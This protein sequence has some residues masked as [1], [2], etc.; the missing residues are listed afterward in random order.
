MNLRYVPYPLLLLIV[1]A[2]YFVAAEIGL[3]QASLH[4]NV[5]PVWPPT[6]FAIAAVWLLGY[7]I[8]PGILLGAFLANLLTGVPIATAGGISV[9]NTLE[10]IT[11]VFLLRHFVGLRNP[12]YRAQDVLRFVLIAGA[13]SPAVSATIGNV[14]LCLGGA[15]A[16]ASFG[17]LWITWWLGDAVGALVIAPLLLTWV[18]ESARRWA[19]RRLAEA[20]L[21]LVSLSVVAYSISGA[22]PASRVVNYSLWRL[23]YA[24]LLWAAFRFG[25]SGVATTIAL[26]LGIAVWATRQGFGPIVGNTPNESLLLLQIFVAAAATTFL[27]LAAIVNERKRAEE[28]AREK[29]SELEEI[30]NHTP[31]MLTRCSCDLRYLFVSRAYAEMIGRTPEELAGKPIAEIMGEEGLKTISPHIEQVLLGKRVEYETE[32]SFRGVGAPCLH[33]V[34]TPDR[35]TQGNVTGWFAS[36]I[37]ITDRK[38]AEEERERLLS[39]E[40]SMRSEAERVSRLKDEFLATISHE[41]RT[42]LNAILGWSHVLRGGRIDEA[43]SSRVLETIERNAKAQ[44]QLIEDLLDVSRIIS[45]KLRLDVK[46]VDLTSVIKAAIDSFQHAADAKGIQLQMVLDPA[47]GRI[48]GDGARLQQVVW[49]LLSNAVKFSTKGGLVQVRLERADSSA[50]I[51]VSDTGEGIAPEFLPYVFDRFQQADGTTT[52]RYGGLGLGLAIAR[53]IVEIHG[54][55]IEAHSAGLRQG[56]S[57]TVRLP[58]VAV[59]ASG[60][61]PTLDRGSAIQEQAATADASIL[62]GLRVLAVDDEP[63]TR[64]MLKAVLE[65][66]G[67]DVA[68]AASAREAFETLPGFGPDVLVCD[69]GMPEEDG[70]TL[71]RKVRALKPEHGGKTRAIALTGYVR[72]EERMRA[73]E[74]GYQMFVPK[75][76]EPDELVSIIASLVGRIEKGKGS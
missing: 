13:L 58:L 28:V 61:L 9:G 74:S 68:T 42:P 37:D 59:R 38:L 44:A 6:G 69:I 20:A 7:R 64:D 60:H 3:S 12:F 63:D 25:P 33:V 10:A 21:L 55:T 39:R 40:R 51:T 36:I 66:Y 57:F 32:V 24:F 41:L 71:I 1:A 14:S 22:V 27:L 53:H 48:Q 62:Y 70:Y 34:Y 16:W 4:T 75:P 52:R 67:A 73:L 26:F 76:V 5:S 65:Q 72:V 19:L 15:A 35:D 49:N 18:E 43:S 56:A 11:A 8:S 54:G 47:A 23:V 45:G 30:I 17:G 29:E 46:S 31:F 50:Q 2:A